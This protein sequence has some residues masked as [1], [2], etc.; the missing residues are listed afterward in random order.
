MSKLHG[1]LVHFTYGSTFNLCTVCKSKASRL[2]DSE[3]PGRDGMID[4]IE[5]ND[6]PDYCDDDCQRKTGVYSRIA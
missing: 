3:C 5:Y 2:D 6:E 1:Y 4:F